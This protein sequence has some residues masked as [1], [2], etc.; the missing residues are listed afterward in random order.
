MADM[1]TLQCHTARMTSP[2]LH[3]VSD[4]L[5]HAAVT[6]RTRQACVRSSRHTEACVTLHASHKGD[7]HQMGAG[8]NL[9]RVSYCVWAAGSP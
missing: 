1:H 3:V 2:M 6:V 7:G 5:P 4:R 9:H 8:C